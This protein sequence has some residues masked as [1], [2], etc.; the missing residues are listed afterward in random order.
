[1]PATREGVRS[2]IV[3]SILSAQQPEDG[4]ADEEAEDA[5]CA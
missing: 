4:D 1:M 5:P 2:P 3:G